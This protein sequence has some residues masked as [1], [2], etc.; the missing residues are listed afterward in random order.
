MD[1]NGLRV[2]TVLKRHVLLSS[3][4]ADLCSIMSRNTYAVDV[5]ELTSKISAFHS[6]SLRLHLMNR[7]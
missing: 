4:D 1:I 7:G 6:P 3:Y 2:Y 5:W